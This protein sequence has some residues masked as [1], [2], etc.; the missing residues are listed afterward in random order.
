M[1]MGY[2]ASPFCTRTVLKLGLDWAFVM[3]S[4]GSRSILASFYGGSDS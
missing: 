4:L 2:F 3:S 1:S